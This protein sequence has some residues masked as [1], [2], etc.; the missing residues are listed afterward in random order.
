MH[1]T[2]A[3]IY[4]T[5]LTFSIGGTVMWAWNDFGVWLIAVGTDIGRTVRL[6]TRAALLRLHL[7]K[8]AV[9]V[10][11]PAA[12]A[13]MIGFATGYA[14]IGDAAT[15]ADKVDFL[16][17]A[18]GE[19]ETT[20]QLLRRDLDAKIDQVRND[21]RTAIASEVQRLSGDNIRVRRLGVALVI[22]GVILL[23]VAPF[24]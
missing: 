21:L 5:G 4:A 23:G 19:H 6:G 10:E 13:T 7:A 24:A 3:A 8:P 9:V 16:L 18:H 15:L 22:I 17:R 20:I 12:T 1:P 2:Q 14:T 11:A